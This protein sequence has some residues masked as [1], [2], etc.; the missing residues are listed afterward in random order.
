MLVEQREA[1]P[2]GLAHAVRNRQLATRGCRETAA[3][4]E[5]PE[6]LV[7]EER[8]ALGRLPDRCCGRRIDRVAV[9]GD[10]RSDLVV[11]EPAQQQ[12]GAFAR[13]PREQRAGLGGQGRVGIPAGRDDEHAHPAQLA[14]DELQQQQRA[15]V[16]D[17]EVVEHD[18]ERP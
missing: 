18:R 16:R 12:G 6:Q 2:D 4:D 11:C 15:D 14:R 1:L 7:Q 5:Q 8:V 3:A 9:R 10:H 13:D 17:V